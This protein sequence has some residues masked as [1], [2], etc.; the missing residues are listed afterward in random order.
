[1]RKFSAALLFLFFA[2]AARAEWKIVS[3][4]SEPS[5]TTGLEHRH[6]VLENSDGGD[7]AT[8][9]L[10]LFSAKSC[11]LRVID[12][13]D[14]ASDLAET[15]LREKCVAGINGGYFD[16]NFAP[17]GLRVVDGRLLKP[18]IRAR[19]LTGVL[20]SSS[21]GIQMV[22]V[23]EFSRGQKLDAA[24]ECGPCL[25]D[26]AQPVR[27]LDGTRS[28]R[29]TFVAIDR[30]DRAALGFCTE[31]SLA[32]LGR[33]L[34][35]ASLAGDFKIW[36]ALNFDGGSSSGFWFKRKDGTAFSISEQKTVR[37]FVAIVPR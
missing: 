27:G 10:A 13:A 17:I 22:R 35:T 3:A 4:Q 37:D 31:V 23:G 15:M 21:R 18:L 8:V 28:A 14:G 34:S 33:I 7:R 12:N 6:V 32:E 11:A 29:R 1:V 19:L 20:T 2:T 16:P 9:E 5:T 24:I 36:R 26:L 30:R 25:V